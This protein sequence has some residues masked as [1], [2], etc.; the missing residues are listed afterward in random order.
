MSD[1]EIFPE[2]IFLQ[3]KFFL[4]KIPRNHFRI[5]QTAINYPLY[6]VIRNSDTTTYWEIE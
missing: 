4:T 2:D 3:N 6:F 5:F 1:Y